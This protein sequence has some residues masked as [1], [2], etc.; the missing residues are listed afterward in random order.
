MQ[1]SC[2]VNFSVG[3]LGWLCKDPSDQGGKVNIDG[4]ESII[5]Q[6]SFLWDNMATSCG[7]RDT[8]GY[9]SYCVGQYGWKK[10][11]SSNQQI[12]GNNEEKQ[13]TL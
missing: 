10:Q 5:C 2:R 4:S 3:S 6:C 9:T 13:E 8:G 1:Y 7:C 11:M 12:G